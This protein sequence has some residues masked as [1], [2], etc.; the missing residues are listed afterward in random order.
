MLN[1]SWWTGDS[2]WS[3]TLA[4]VSQGSIQ[5]KKNLPS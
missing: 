5:R 3:N 4:N 2:N 1:L